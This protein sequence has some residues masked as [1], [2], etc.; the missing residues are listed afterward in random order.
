[1][2]D[3]PLRIVLSAVGGGA[4]SSVASG[5]AGT[6][7]PAGMVGAAL[8]GLGA[9]SVKASAD[10]QNAMLQNEAH[11]GLAASQ[12]GAVNKALLAMGPA[13]GQGPTQLAQALYP[14]LSG[15][16]GITNQAAKTQVSLTE[17]KLAAESVAGSTTSVTTVSNAA[18]AAFNALGLQTNNTALAQQR[19]TTLFDEMNAT[20]SSGN[21]HWEEYANVAGKLA[22][23]IK[24]TNL[25][26]TEANAALA[27]MT[28]EG[29]SARLSE[30]YLANFFTQLETKTDSLANNAKK[31]GI[32]F[33]ENKFKSMSLAQQVQYLTQ[34]THGNQAEMLKLL[35]NN[36]T[37]LKTYNAL[38]SGMSQYKS[39]LQAIGHSQGTTANDFAVASQG[40]NFSLQR[41]N[42][43]FQSLEISIGNIFLPMLTS[44]A[45]ALVPVVSGL[46]SWVAANQG[47]TT[48][49]SNAST[50][51][52]PAIRQLAIQAI[53]LSEAFSFFVM[54]AVSPLTDQF[55]HS[56]IVMRLQ[57]IPGLQATADWMQHTGTP[58]YT[59]FAQLV[60]DVV[61]GSF[62]QARQDATNLAMTI[63]ETLSGVPGKI[64]G[65][66]LPGL[67]SSPALGGLLAGFQQLSHLASQLQQWLAPAI[68]WLQTTFLPAMHAVFDPIGEM[69]Q[70]VTTDMGPQFQQFF[71]FL[72]DN[73]LADFGSGGSGSASVQNFNFTWKDLWHTIGQ[74]IEIFLK[75]WIYCQ[76]FIIPI[77]LK[78]DQVV[79]W[80]GEHLAGPVLQDLGMH[81]QFW[82][83]LIDWINKNAMPAFGNFMSFLSGFFLWLPQA[84]GRAIGNVLG[85]FG[86]LK[87]QLLHIL[88]IIVGAWHLLPIDIQV[89]INMAVVWLAAKFAEL[90]NLAYIWG[91][92]FIQ[93]LTNGIQSA[94]GGLINSIKQLA[95]QI[96][97]YLHF[98]KPDTGPLASIDTWMPDMMNLLAQGIVAGSPKI[99]SALHSSLSP[100]APLGA[101]GSLPATAPSGHTPAPGVAYAIT[102]NLSTMARTQS[103]VRTLVDL[104]E[105]ELG[106][107]VRS[108]TPGYN[109]GNIF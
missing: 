28:N 92:D 35:G 2:T 19:M 56:S 81:L 86:S 13:V 95:G 68:S 15:F 43:A 90:K 8:L 39:N 105:Q 23:A 49:I 47:I 70:Q 91:R 1:M 62:A 58:V 3:I 55:L 67:P 99:Q 44:I 18:T 93:A 61:G 54:H 9:V 71:E 78:V 17:L 48:S 73:V 82:K 77:V 26:F 101:G 14:I 75:F 102:I 11:A 63:T 85:W 87:D 100:L 60:R 7:G 25:S 27:T 108:H 96:G 45:N 29:Y 106:R 21:M 53:T 40:F 84:T 22:T 97:S 89:Y 41:L 32:S 51:L 109:S 104:I 52:L 76:E 79:L 5:I 42:A 37:A 10:F 4:L 12:V 69:I 24:G 31:L 30:T 50:G 46:A 64:S 72:Q 66:S 107:R 6:F 20:V 98:S 88:N 65:P 83:N 16:S 33:D 38:S 94:V 80:L 74:I 57:Y 103:E 36:A 34:I 59:S